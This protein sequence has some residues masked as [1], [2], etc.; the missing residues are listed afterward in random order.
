MNANLSSGYG[1]HV[2]PTVA[3]NKAIEE[4]IDLEFILDDNFPLLSL[5]IYGNEHQVNELVLVK[6]SVIET[7]NCILDTENSKRTIQDDEMFEL[8]RF[9]AQY[10]LEYNPRWICFMTVFP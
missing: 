9:C 10:H 1:I 3:L 7:D 5:G 4:Q 8:Q 6:S 2:V